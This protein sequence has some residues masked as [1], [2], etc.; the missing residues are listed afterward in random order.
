MFD[1]G[2]RKAVI[3]G[4]AGGVAALVLVIVLQGLSLL[5]VPGRAQALRAADQVETV[6]QSVS[7]LERRLTALEAMADGLP[8][9]RA[10]ARAASERLSALEA[11]AR[12]FVRADD[13]EALSADI[14]ALR[15][16][17]SEVP[18]GVPAEE[19]A[20]LG[21]RISRLEV[22]IASGAAGSSADAEAAIESLTGQIG[23]TSAA[24][25][26]LRDRLEA[27]EAKLA[28]L[29]ETRADA[30]N[31]AAMRAVAVTALRR[32]A[33]GAVPFVT[34]LDMAASLGIAGDAVA[35]LRSYAERGVRSQAALAGEFPQVADAILAA[36]SAPPSD[37][38]IMDRVVAGLG[39]L[40]SV[41]PAGPIPGSDPQAV[42]SRMVAAAKAQD[43]KTV[44]AERAAL[45]E[46]AQAASAAWAREAED[47]I[48]VDDLVEQIARSADGSNG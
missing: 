25:Q 9:A 35:A 23:S 10:D 27:A 29:E 12:S 36:V 14:A 43:L 24:M 11:S 34:E 2:G 38:G 22:A 33:A 44:L 39:S 17:V 48:A 3:A 28:E 4:V 45:P 1:D 31:D 19:L 21:E 18:A 13:V 5:P 7:A 42:V 20:Q 40:V 37:A 30:G 41:R 8:A 26:A 32:G 46:N 6:S 47:R 16:Q 15:T